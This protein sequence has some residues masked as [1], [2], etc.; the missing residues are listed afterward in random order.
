LRVALVKVFSVADEVV[1]PFGLGYLAE[2]VRRRGHDAL[3]IDALRDGL[4]EKALVSR[5]AAW[6]PDFVGVLLFTKDL[7]IVRS[8]LSAVRAALPGVKTCVGGPH[9]SAVPAETMRF[10]GHALDFAFAGE[11]ETGLPS[12]L[13]A[14]EKDC[15][16]RGGGAAL[17]PVP[18]LA[19]RDVAGVKANPRIF[20]EDLDSLEVA[21]DLIPP[22][23]YPRA[24]HGA[25]YRR[26]PIAPIVTSRGCP[27]QCTF[28]AAECVSGRKIRRRSAENV[29]GE[30]VR[31]RDRFGVREIHIE[32]DNFTAKKEY[33]LSFCDLMRRR[34]PGMPWTCPN[35]VRLDTLDREMLEAMKGAGLYFLSV[36]IESGSDRVLRR[37]RKSL[38]V[39]RIE[40]KVRLV[41][42]TGIGVSGFFMLGFPGESVEEMEETIAFALRLPLS[43][44][45]FANFQPFPGCEEFERLR[46]SGEIAVDWET[47]APTLQST[48]YHPAGIS[49]GGLRR[50]RKRALRR[51]YARPSTAWGMMKE[52]RSWEHA[53]WILRR[54]WRWLTIET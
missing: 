22:A 35:G 34:V 24:P 6:S 33:V 11:A 13:D 18:G 20:E 32:D 45:S 43:R 14:L 39:E 1:P 26:F 19:W 12:L 4:G 31:L 52:I 27:Y 17:D 37:M 28:C 41:R 48:S 3:V 15:G 16:K 23:S 44:A 10:F 8:L 36:G 9:P 54:G 21:W 50:L 7:R 46:G 49:A 29:V 40:E 42:E 2:S 30:I 5:L 38:T 51:F 25:Y 53:A 47:F